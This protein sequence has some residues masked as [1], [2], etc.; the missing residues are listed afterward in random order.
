MGGRCSHL[1]PDSQLTAHSAEPA[2]RPH[3]D[4]QSRLNSSAHLLHAAPAKAHLRILHPTTGTPPYFFALRMSAPYFQRTVKKRPWKP[5]EMSLV[6]RPRKRRPVTP[7][8]AMT[9]F[10]AS[11]YPMGTVDVCV[12]VLRTR[13]ELEMVS[14]TA[15]A[16][17]PMMAER[18]RYLAND[19]FLSTSGI[20]AD[21]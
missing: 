10:A 17:K 5:L 15:V 1:N 13:T 18:P 8:L 19:W 16:E 2:A 11:T 6:P 4:L 9:I 12:V 20:A 3:N 7:S 21:M 14:E